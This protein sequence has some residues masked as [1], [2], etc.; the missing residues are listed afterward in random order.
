MINRAEILQQFLRWE[1]LL[2]KISVEIGNGENI[3]GYKISPVVSG[4]S[5]DK[6]KLARRSHVPHPLSGFLDSGVI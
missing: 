5:D 2:L 3:M 1:M 6:I 4:A